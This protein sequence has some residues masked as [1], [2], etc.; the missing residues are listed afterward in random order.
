VSSRIR[1]PRADFYDCQTVAALFVSGALSGEKTGLSF[2]TAAGPRQR[3]YI[4][5][6]KISSARHLYLQFYMPAFYSQLSNSQV[7][8]GHLLLI[9][10]RVVLRH[11]PASKDLNTE[12][13]GTMTL[14]AVARQRRVK[15]QQTEKSS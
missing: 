7:P 9:V 11:S 10:L 14:K 1:D 3:S 4:Y 6:G 15:T 8:C 5:C 13:E 2:T 12:V